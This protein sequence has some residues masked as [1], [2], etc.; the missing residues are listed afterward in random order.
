M[1]HGAIQKIKVAR[2]LWTMVYMKLPLGDP[3]YPESFISDL[4]R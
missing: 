3:A 2:Y 1:L 4:V